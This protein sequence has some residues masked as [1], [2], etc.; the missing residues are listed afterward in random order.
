MLLNVR[1][2]SVGENQNIEF[3]LAISMAGEGAISWAVRWAG[4]GGRSRNPP[5]PG[6]DRRE[7]RE[8]KGTLHCPHPTS[9]AGQ[10]QS[11]APRG[12]VR[13]GSPTC[14]FHTWLYVSNLCEIMHHGSLSRTLF[15]IL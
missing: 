14:I 2:V 11:P 8:E 10:Q 5:H 4:G 15:R 9:P 7:L 6:A 13:Q 3:G 12:N 1:D